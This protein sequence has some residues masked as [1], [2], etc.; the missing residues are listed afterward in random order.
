MQRVSCHR[1]E[2]AD[3]KRKGADLFIERKISLVEAK[4]IRAVKLANGMMLS[5]ES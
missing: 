1:K 5:R 2:H 4:L 3:F